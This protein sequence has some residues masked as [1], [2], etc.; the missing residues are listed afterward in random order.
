MDTF[1]DE[2]DIIPSPQTS[3]FEH[4]ITRFD[5]YDWKHRV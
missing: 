2:V 4:S 5:F 3:F 1:D